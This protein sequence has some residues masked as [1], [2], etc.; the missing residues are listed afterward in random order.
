VIQATERPASRRP[1]WRGVD[2][3][4]VLSLSVEERR[5]REE[6]Q[7]RAKADEDRSGKGIG[8]LLDGQ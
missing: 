7:R 8:A 6:E 3:V 4:V 1:P 5:K 2:P